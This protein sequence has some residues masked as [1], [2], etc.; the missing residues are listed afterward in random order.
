MKRVL[1]FGLLGFILILTGCHRD[2]K[3]AID[4]YQKME[5]SAS[6]ET[7]FADDLKRLETNGKKAQAVY[8]KLIKLNINDTDA[9]KQKINDANTYTEKQQQLLKEARQSFQKAY[10]QSAMI[11]KNVKKIKDKEQK[12]QATKLITLMKD[13]KKL[14]GNFFDDYQEQLEL[15][16]KVYQQLENGKFSANELDKHINEIN[17]QN[18]DMEKLI[19]QFNQ[20]TKKYNEAEND[21]YQLAQLN[22]KDMEHT[23]DK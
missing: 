19:Q 22:Q 3:Q 20:S 2:E 5:K 6:L 13:R 23:A 12:K 8:N 17:K 11:R 4:I 10:K 7:E 15:Q 1:L 14:I 21:Y 16:Q 9:I 18:E